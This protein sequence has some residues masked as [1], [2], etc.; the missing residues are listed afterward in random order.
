MQ[1]RSENCIYGRLRADN[2][3]R[4]MLPKGSLLNMEIRSCQN[5]KKELAIEPDDFAF[6]D[7]L[8]V[9]P[10]TWCSQCRFVR[11]LTFIN[12][13]SLFK[14]VCE[15]CQKSIISMYSPETPIPVWCVKCHVSDAWDGRDYGRDYDF[16]RS[17]FEQ[18]KELKEVTPHR[19]LD[20]NERNGTGCEYSNYCFT[21]KDVYLSFSVTGS[22]YVKYSAHIFKGNK[23]CVD[24]LSI[25]DSDRLYESVQARQN[26]NS[27]FLIESDQC[28][29]SHFL[30]DCSNCVNCCLS[31][32][33][34]NKSYVFRNKQLTREEYQKRVADL[35][36]H[37]Y[38]GQLKVKKEF[39][40]IAKGA[41]HRY[42]H[43]TNSVNVVGDFIEN[44]KN[45]NHS[46]G[47]V[48][49]EDSK[50]VYFAMNAVRDSQ[51]L[52][53]CGMT[54]ECYEFMYGGRG[55]NKVVFGISCGGGCKNLFYC[56]NCRGCSDCF[57]C[58]GLDKK[59]YCILNKQYTK[60]EYEKMMPE[61]I[62]HMKEMPYKDKNGKVY[63]FGEFFPTEISQ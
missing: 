16:N 63:P 24:S 36:L 28:V 47:L 21:S 6:Y 57:G 32:N 27:S 33:L 34:R 15:N 52:M 61:I 41:I 39:E 53:F 50:N 30:F 37:T 12:H 45:I 35:N 1:C 22:E 9:P 4:K 56:D 18:F 8:K 3:L 25:K 17:F 11:R 2:L 19:S 13:R 49:A 46:Y 14:R 59:Q 48:E 44:S 20:Q 42:A 43:I 58:V 31:S 5:C 7:K 54:E 29:E 60:E 23:N 40:E 51:D 55:A 10:P 62:E 38:S 26:Y